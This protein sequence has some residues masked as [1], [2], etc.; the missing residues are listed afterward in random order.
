MASELFTQLVLLLSAGVG[1]LAVGGINLL[2]R[3][4]PGLVRGV[5]TLLVGGAAVGMA[6]AV[7]DDLRVARGVS[8]ILAAGTAAVVLS[9]SGRLAAAVATVAAPFRRP[10]V[11]WGLLALAGIVTMVGALALYDLQD[12]AAL[13]RAMADLELLTAQPPATTANDTLARTDHGSPVTVREATALRGEADLGQIEQHIFKQAALRE[14]AIRRHAA[15]DRF[16][17]HGWVFTGGRFWVPSAAIDAILAENGYAVTPAPA[18]GDVVIYRDDAGRVTH[19]AVVRAVAD[20]GTVLAEGKWGAMGVYL[21]EVSASTYGQRFAFYRSPRAGHL[22]RG[23][24]PLPA[25]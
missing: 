18:A 2:L 7:A 12:E 4:K 17:C 6:W 13:D 24:E 14:S 8:L 21:H 15:D 16:N 23:L 9:Q 19:T 11:G 5:L 25:Q 3:R 22:L 20:D 10:A 1:L